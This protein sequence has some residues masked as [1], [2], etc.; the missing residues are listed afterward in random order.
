[1]Q[2]NVYIT[3]FDISASCFFPEERYEHLKIFDLEKF[4]KKIRFHVKTIFFLFSPKIFPR[5]IY[6]RRIIYVFPWNQKFFLNF[7]PVKF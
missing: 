1:M 7:S 4:E 2:K 3:I 6:V 5:I